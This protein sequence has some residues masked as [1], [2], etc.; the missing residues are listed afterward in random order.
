MRTT[1][2]SRGSK[3]NHITLLPDNV[4]SSLLPAAGPGPQ[5]CPD[6]PHLPDAFN[7]L[8]MR[9]L[10]LHTNA[11]QELDGSVFRMLANLQNISLQNNRS[12][13]PRKPLRQCQ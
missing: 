10:S 12:A 7:G 2:G 5:P 3:D 6:Q 8:V 4:F 1:C 11:L 9:E 13:A